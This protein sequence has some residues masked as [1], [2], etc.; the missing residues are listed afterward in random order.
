VLRTRV[1]YAG[2]ATQKPTYYGMGDHTEAIAIDFDP[3]VISYEKLLEYF[4]SGHRCGSNFGGSQY[5]NVVFYHGDGQKKL[6]E[7]W[8]GIAAKKQGIAEGQVKTGLFPATPFTYAEDY[9]Q[10]HVLSRH[11]EVRAFLEKT[12]PGAKELA[13][14]M[15]ATRLNAWLGAGYVTDREVLEK[16]IESYGLPEKLERYVLASVSKS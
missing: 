4:W 6:A 9:H 1:G 10:K 5:R 3:K 11:P 16:E 12:Y 8:R 14:S 7:K 15:V 2:G 13:D